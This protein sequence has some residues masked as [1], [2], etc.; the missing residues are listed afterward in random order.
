MKVFYHN[1]LDGHCAGWLVK[2]AVDSGNISR[3]MDNSVVGCNVEDVQYIQLS[4]NHL[5]KTELVSPNEGCILV[6]IS[7]SD[8]T[9]NY[10]K[11]LHDICGNNLI[12]IDHHL[13]SLNLMKN[14][15]WADKIQGVRDD[16]FCGAYLTYCYFNSKISKDESTVPMFV[17]YVDDWDCWKLKL[18]GIKAFK[19]AMDAIETRPD[20][21]E[22]IWG[23]L[24]HTPEYLTSIIESGRSI[25]EWLNQF[26]Y[27]YRGG[28]GYESIIDGHKCYVCNLKISSD[29]FG[30]LIQDYPLVVGWVYDGKQYN[31]SLYS[32]K[33]DIDC[34]A[35]AEK[36]GG[37]GHKGAAG[38]ISKELILKEITC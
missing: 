14:H 23:T 8:N 37:G 28:H 18:P 20:H 10:L 24:E 15:A 34:S 6:D 22:C 21:S 32:I 26:Y 17:R 5:E 38:F 1:D 11:H 25:E 4:Y 31:Y 2:Q 13:S 19:I 16:A 33:D 36:F 7:F 29:I 30:N 3:F 9:V 35:I 27:R 12:W